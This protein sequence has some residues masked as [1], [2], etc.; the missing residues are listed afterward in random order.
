MTSEVAELRVG[1]AG[2][3]HSKE[4]DL[5]LAGG[6]FHIGEELEHGACKC[7]LARSGFSDNTNALALIDRNVD[8]IDGTHDHF[9]HPQMNLQ[10]PN[11]EERGARRTCGSHVWSPASRP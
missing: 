11:A 9:A 3:I 7:A 10:V 5:A 2:Q 8:P 4:V 6:K 1:Y